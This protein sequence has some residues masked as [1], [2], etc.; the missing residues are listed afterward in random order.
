M[1]NFNHLTCCVQNI[2]F[3]V[4]F[5]DASMNLKAVAANIYEYDSDNNEFKLVGTSRT[6]LTTRKW[7]GSASQAK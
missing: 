2:A 4:C 6:V 3:M 1:H 5:F 7:G